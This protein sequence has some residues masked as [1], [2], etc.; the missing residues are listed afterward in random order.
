M[1]N[2]LFILFTLC[3]FALISCEQESPIIND[4]QELYSELEHRRAPT[5]DLTQIA[6]YIP[7]PETV[8]GSTINFDNKFPV[9]ESNDYETANG[10]NINIQQI[11][12]NVDDL[13]SDS[14]FAYQDGSVY[15][16]SINVDY[17][18]NGAYQQ[19]TFSLCFK[20]DGQTLEWD[21][22]DYCEYSEAEVL[23]SRTGI[24]SII[25]P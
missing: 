9:T 5:C 17:S 10:V 14:Q 22:T 4:T 19:E 18:V 16:L 12:Y 1:K 21:C 2:Y 24:A 15:N 13:P 3:L 6:L 8:Q 7:A 25:M 23:D 11:A 20:I